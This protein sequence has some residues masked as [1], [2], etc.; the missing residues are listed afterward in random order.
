MPWMQ[1]PAPFSASRHL[2]SASCHLF[3]PPSY[4]FPSITCSMS[5]IQYLL[6][7][8][9]CSSAILE[10]HHKLQPTPSYQCFSVLG[11]KKRVVGP[12][13]MNHASV[14]WFKHPHHPH[15]RSYGDLIPFATLLPPGGGRSMIRPSQERQEADIANRNRVGCSFCCSAS[16][17]TGASLTLG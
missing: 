14:F 1:T 6:G 8:P 16:V 4:L 3:P 2:S 17:A 10:Q 11:W 12:T 7:T 5:P 15:P 13:P 9:R